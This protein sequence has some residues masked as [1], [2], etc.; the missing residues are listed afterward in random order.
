MR[1]F[2]SRVTSQ[3]E[4]PQLKMSFLADLRFQRA[5]SST[6]YEAQNVQLKSTSTS[7]WPEFPNNILAS[8]VLSWCCPSHLRVNESSFGR[9]NGHPML[10]G[11]ISFMDFWMREEMPKLEQCTQMRKRGSLSASQIY[12]YAKITNY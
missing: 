6:I 3:T 7:V 9:N 12:E 11:C 1:H 2:S 4:I 10:C 5:K 8:P